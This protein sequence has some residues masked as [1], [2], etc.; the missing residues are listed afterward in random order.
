MTFTE[1]QTQF[2]LCKSWEERYRLL[3]KLSR[4]LPTPDETELATIPEIHG[5]ESRLWFCFQTN[6]RHIQAYSDARLMQGLLAIIIAYVSEKSDAELKTINLQAVF[7]DLKIANN[8][9]ST[10]LNGINQISEII[11]MKVA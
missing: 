4:T 6:P 8:L 7:S 2:A 1:I 3:I 10:R 11:K 9:T 5:C